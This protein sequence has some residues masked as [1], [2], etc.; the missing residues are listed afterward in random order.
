M[1]T[2]AKRI[3]STALAMMLLSGVSVASAA[4]GSV[5]FKE[6]MTGAEEVPVGDL[7]GSG[8][9]EIDIN[10]ETGEVCYDIKHDDIGAPNR[11]H[12]HVGGAGTPGGIVVTLFELREVPLDARNDEIEKGRIQACVQVDPAVLEPILANPA[13]YYVNIHNSRFPPGALRCQLVS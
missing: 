2:G 9:A 7:D 5:R 13:G 10:G 4:D 12:I 1:R 6:A 3:L 11:G 8:K